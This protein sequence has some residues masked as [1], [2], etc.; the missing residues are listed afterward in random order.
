M[1]LIKYF[2]SLF[3]LVQLQYTQPLPWPEAQRRSIESTD[4]LISFL[5]T[6]L[7]SHVHARRALFQTRWYVLLRRGEYRL[8]TEAFKVRQLLQQLRAHGQVLA[9]RPLLA[10]YLEQVED[11]RNLVGVFTLE[12]FMEFVLKEFEPM[13]SVI[14]WVTYSVRTQREFARLL[15]EV[16]NNRCHT[17]IR[18]L[19]CHYLPCI[20]EK[21]VLGLIKSLPP[22][23]PDG[24]NLQLMGRGSALEKSKA[25]FFTDLFVPFARTGNQ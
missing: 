7:H 6:A 5:Q 13:F 1:P 22:L 17:Q 25:G 12:T 8:G 18:L 2:L 23:L 21:E 10:L 14:P 4:Q 11:K 20:H 19:F 9:Q 16:Q 24:S 15:P 3:L